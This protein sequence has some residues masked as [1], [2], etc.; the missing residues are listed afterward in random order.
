MPYGAGYHSTWS[1]KA[2]IH[3]KV[4]TA[5]MLLIRTSGKVFSN[6]SKAIAPRCEFPIRIHIPRQE[7][8][9]AFIMSWPSHN[10]FLVRGSR[11]R[12]SALV[13]RSVNVSF[14]ICACNASLL[15]L[16]LIP[17]HEKARKWITIE[18]YIK[19]C[20][21][22]YLQVICWALKRASDGCFQASNITL[23][24]SSITEV[25]R[26]GAGCLLEVV[27]M[28]CLSCKRRV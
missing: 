3:N 14:V 28:K 22:L 10:V 24:G 26:L 12:T 23:L 8:D 11:T 21:T 16:C 13:D 1:I 18:F 6:T 7:F 15:T 17:I 4:I 2:L 20:R 25:E 19:A 9:V 5:G 27:F